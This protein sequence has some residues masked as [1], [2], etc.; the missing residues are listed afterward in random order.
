M[1]GNGAY[2]LAALCQ[3]G[4]ADATKDLL[5]DAIQRFVKASHAPPQRLTILDLGASQGLNSL[6]LVT[7]L[8]QSLDASL[9]SSPPHVL[10]LHEDQPANDFATLLTTLNSPAS[11]IHTRP[12]TFTGVIAKSFYDPVVPP[13]SIEIAVS[14][15][16]VQWLASVPT[17]LPG[18]IICVNHHQRKHLVPSDVMRKWQTAAHDDFIAFLRLRATE[19]ADDGLLCLTH[20][21]NFDDEDEDQPMWAWANQAILALDDVVATGLMSPASLNRIAVGIYF[22]TTAESREA[23]TSVADV[24]RLDA[25]RRIEMTYPFPHGAAAAMFVMAIFKPSFEAGMTE[26]E[27]INPDVARGLL[28]AMATRLSQP[29]KSGEPFYRCITVPYVFAAFTRL[30]RKNPTSGL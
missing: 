7:Y 28:D 12:G 29:D 27:R 23:C 24:L 6:A 14:Y 19:L 22:R 2:N 21:A 13:A 10:V 1:E 11:Y 9:P 3:R 4:V 25:H 5:D 15:I 8:L 30:R 26:A 16:A 20:T 18:S 17:P